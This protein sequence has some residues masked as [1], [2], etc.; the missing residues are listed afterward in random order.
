MTE[1]EVTEL[2][3]IK[4]KMAKGILV[5]MCLEFQNNIEQPPIA[6]A[7]LYKQA[8]V[9]DGP[10]IEAFRETWISNIREN[11]K[12]FGSFKEKSIGK[13]F[14]KYKYRPCFVAGAGPSLKKNGEE[15]KNRGDI[16]LVSCLHNFH[17]FEDRGI[18]VEFYVTLD[19]GK[20]TVEEVSE[21]GA[22]PPEWYWERTKGKVL[23]AYIGTH[24]ELLKKWQG[25]IYFYNSPIPDDKIK[26]A[27]NEIEPFNCYVSTGGN[28]LGACLYIAKGFFGCSTIAFVGADFSFSY[29]K[30]FHAW[31]SKYDAALGYVLK[32]CDIYGNKVLT[33]QSYNNFKAFF[34][35][36]CCQVPGFWV[37]CTEGGTL[38]S[39]Y[40]GNISAIKQMRLKDFISMHN[41]SDYLIGQVNSPEVENLTILF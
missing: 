5:E 4:D 38:G 34:D 23:C 13:F 26:A 27:L 31:D 21:G 1:A 36:L 15:L 37:N 3:V 39:Y 40:E 7:D 35:Q 18:N 30:K 20:V 24:P 16:P 29:T 11:K 12:T 22:N 2:Q 19:A 9:G 17:F 8:C 25:E 10:T 14:N 6:P 33:W 28:V 32:A 41:M